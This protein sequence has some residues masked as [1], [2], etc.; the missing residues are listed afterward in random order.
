L[1]EKW[2]ETGNFSG[3]KLLAVSLKQFLQANH[4][5]RAGA[6]M[7]KRIMAVRGSVQIS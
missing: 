5:V 7:A 6:A 4:F 1:K 2:R 3:G